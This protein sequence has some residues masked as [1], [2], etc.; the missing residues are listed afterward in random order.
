MG[1][2]QPLALRVNIHNHGRSARPAVEVRLEIDGKPARTSRI[3]LE[4]DQSAQVLFTAQFDTPGDHAIKVALGHDAVPAD[5]A[6]FS[7]IPV[8]DDVPVLLVDG[9]PD[10]R[11]LASETDF[12]RLALRPFSEA[13]TELRDLIVTETVEAQRFNGRDTEGKRVVIVANASEFRDDQVKALEQFVSSGGGLIVFPGDRTKFDSFNRRL[14]RDGKGLLPARYAELAGEVAGGAPTRIRIGR[15][16]HAAMHLFND[17]RNGDPSS[18]A[19][20]SWAV[21]EPKAEGVTKVASLQSGDVFAVEQSFGDGR[22][23]QMAVPADADWGNLPAQPEFVPMMQ[24]FVVHLATSAQTERNFAVGKTFTALLPPDL[25]GSKLE[26]ERPSGRSE[27]IEVRLEGDRGILNYQ[28]T[29]SPGHYTLRLPDGEKQIFAANF[30][31]EESDVTLLSDELLARLAEESDA[32]I[33]TDLDA[34]W[35]LDKNRRVGV[36]IWKPLLGLLIALLIAEIMLQ[37]WIGRRK[38]KPAKSKPRDRAPQPA[39]VS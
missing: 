25:A 16:D 39:P 5:N 32:A 12:L 14:H 15:F 4:P 22:V 37:Q 30:P 35:E 21:L 28:D 8:W 1:I 19:L 26:V 27:N 9:D 7:S 10:S 24:R 18:A 23:L 31:R 2:G 13:K 11:P 20:R 36:E 34:Y 6:W 33:A 17:A 3:R 29:K 38:L